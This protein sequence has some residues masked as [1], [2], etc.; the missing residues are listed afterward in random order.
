MISRQTSL[1]KNIVQ[2]CRFL[3]QQNFTVGVEEEIAALNALQF[4][5]YGNNQ[6]FR[7]ALQAVLCRSRAQIETFDSL[8][9]QYWKE[10]AT[11]VDAKVK[12]SE[13][14]P[15]KP[16]SKEPSFKALKSWLHSNQNKEEEQ[17]ALYSL[18]E[19]LSQKDFSLVPADELEELMRTIKALSKRLAAQV[20]RRYKQA[21]KPGLPDLRR[22]LRLNMRRGGELLDIAF[23]KPKRNRTRLVILCDVSKSMELYATFLLQFMYSFQQVYSRMETFVFGTS[24]Q[25]ISPLL[26]QND[27][28]HAMHLVSAQGESWSSG[29]RIGES[30]H[31]FVNEHASRI[32]NKRTIVMILSD[33]W[34]TGDVETLRQSMKSIKALSRK[35]IWLNPLAGFAG[36]RPETAGMLAAL[37]YVDVLAPVH[38]VDSLRKLSRWI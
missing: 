26:K 34:D 19:N 27:F 9:N 24:L 6:V 16:G 29:T 15:A 23:R 11:A 37:P 3:R 36:Y 22:T 18:Q 5:D 17:T 1:S 12:N 8:F 38:N 31:S 14:P 35:I 10:L 7:L 30:L 20:N 13:E 25:Y 21:N 2:F 4:I 32:L 28:T 33:G